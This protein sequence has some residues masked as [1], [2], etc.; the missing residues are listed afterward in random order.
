[1]LGDG[2]LGLL[3][4]ADE[5]HAAAVGDGLLDELVRA[6]DMRQRLLQVDDVDAVAL[7]EDEA[8]HLRVPAPGLMPEVDARVEHFPHGDDGHAGRG[9]LLLRAPGSTAGRCLGCRGR[10]GWPTALVPGVATMFCR[11]ARTG[12]TEVA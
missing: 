1:L 6:V 3:L 7:G 12:R 9:S 4:R 11:P 5:E 10:A 2:F 8:L